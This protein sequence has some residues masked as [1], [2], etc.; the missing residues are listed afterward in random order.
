MGGRKVREEKNRFK[1]NDP[2]N[3]NNTDWKCPRVVG[4][5]VAGVYISF[6]P[7]TLTG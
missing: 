4:G 7:G 2:Y 6:W 1:E 3:N 5:A